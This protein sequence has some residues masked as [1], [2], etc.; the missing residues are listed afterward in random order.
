MGRPREHDETT[1][2]A[3]IAA[4]AELLR[5]GGAGAVSVRAVA[6]RVGVS[7]RGV[8]SLFGSMEGLLY[9]LGE[10]GFELLATM[11]DEVPVTADPIADLISV[12]LDGWR[13]WALGHPELYRLTF[14]R[15][16]TGEPGARTV[17][18]AGLTALS[19]LRSRVQRAVDA[20]LLGGRTVDEVTPQVHALTEGLT[21]M[22]LRGRLLGPD[23][24]RM[25]RAALEALIAGLSTPVEVKPRRRTK[26]APA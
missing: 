15:L 26:R 5:E 11:V 22:Q 19:R 18:A 9:A 24:E 21:V 16:V 20:G 4:A 17:N 8:Y 10:H 23:P 12:C 2:A 6:D 3:L 7:T 1:R 25:W 14:D 13:R